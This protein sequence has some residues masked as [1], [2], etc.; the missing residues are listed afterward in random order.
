MG[1]TDFFFMLCWCSGSLKIPRSCK[2]RTTNSQNFLQWN[3]EI[4]ELSS[5][6]PNNPVSFGLPCGTCYFNCRFRPVH[7]YCQITL[8]KLRFFWSDEPRQTEVLK[9]L[10]FQIIHVFSI[11]TFSTVWARPRTRYHRPR[12]KDSNTQQ[13]VSLFWVLSW[14]KVSDT[15]RYDTIYAILFCIKSF[16]S[17]HRHRTIWYWK[18]PNGRRRSQSYCFLHLPFPWNLFS[19]QMSVWD[20]EIYTLGGFLHSSSRSWS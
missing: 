11:G 5:S 18:L 20:G 15:V 4:C 10:L 9:N 13:A 1:D 12:S 3:R 7:R 14:F 19:M 6:G 16:F 17:C 2:P 8:T